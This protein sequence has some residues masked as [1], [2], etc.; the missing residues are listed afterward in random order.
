MSKTNG[1]YGQEWKK[2]NA[3]YPLPTVLDLGKKNFV[4]SVNALFDEPP[5]TPYNHED[6]VTLLLRSTG[7]QEPIAKDEEEAQNMRKAMVS[8]PVGSNRE[9]TPQVMTAKTANNIFRLCSIW[10]MEVSANAM[11]TSPS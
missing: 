6:I 3:T 10:A 1:W 4:Y 5:F 2:L 7:G 11:E 8:S 9:P